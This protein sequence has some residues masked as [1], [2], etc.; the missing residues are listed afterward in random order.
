MA[1]RQRHFGAMTQPINSNAGDGN[2][3]TRQNIGEHRTAT[4]KHVFA[5]LFEEMNLVRNF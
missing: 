3:G 1:S 5:P 4:H 2:G